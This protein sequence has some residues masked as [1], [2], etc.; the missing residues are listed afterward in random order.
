MQDLQTSTLRK[1]TAIEY[2]QAIQIV[3]EYVFEGKYCFRD[4]ELVG[5]TAASVAS[6]SQ[7]CIE[8]IEHWIAIGEIE[9]AEYAIASVIQLTR[10]LPA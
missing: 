2:L 4:D 9:E 10:K 3:N 8:E 6:K 5:P 1:T 7:R